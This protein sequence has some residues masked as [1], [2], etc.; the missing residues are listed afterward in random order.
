MLLHTITRW[1]CLLLVGLRMAHAASSR[2]ERTSILPSTTTDTPPGN[3]RKRNDAIPRRPFGI[4]APYPWTWTI[5]ESS[6]ILPIR[7]SASA[8]TI[9]YQ[10]IFE[11]AT[12]HFW[13]RQLEQRKFAFTWGDYRFE[14]FSTADIPWQ[15][16]SVWA[17]VM[18]EAAKRGWTAR[19]K[20]DLVN[21]KSGTMLWIRL[22][23]PASGEPAP[24]GIGPS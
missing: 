11:Q 20:W 5:T 21:Q 3:I 6:C 24:L 2:H 17:F 18:L 13:G 22:L 4:S 9:L 16:I 15:L 10:S 1:L 14:M 19:Y 8:L 23:V 7:P 12:A